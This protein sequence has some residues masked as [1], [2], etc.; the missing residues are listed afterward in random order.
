MTDPDREAVTPR[1][2]GEWSVNEAR[3]EGLSERMSA[4]ARAEH[5]PIASSFLRDLSDAAKAF[6][7]MFRRWSA[8]DVP[9]GQKMREH[10]RFRAFA[11]YVEQMQ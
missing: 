6:T 10:E 5:D 11:A 8:Q 9:A 2:T 1:L 4:M 3:A 7:R